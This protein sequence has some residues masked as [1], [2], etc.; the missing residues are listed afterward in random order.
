MSVITQQYI[1]LIGAETETLSAA[2]TL[3]LMDSIDPFSIVMQCLTLYNESKQLVKFVKKNDINS[4]IDPD[5]A[6]TD[7]LIRSQEKIKSAYGQMDV[8]MTGNRHKF[9]NPLDKMLL[10]FGRCL[11]K[12]SFDNYSLAIIQIMEHDVDADQ[13]PYSKPFDSVDELM[14]HLNS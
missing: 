4:I 5:D 6:L 7:T 11:L 2:V 10:P 1:D 14:K 9:S 13:S 8:F 3:H 12:K